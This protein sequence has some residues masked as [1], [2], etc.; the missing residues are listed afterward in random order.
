MGH[1]SKEKEFKKMETMML[2]IND[3]INNIN[4]NQKQNQNQ[5]QKQNQ[6][7]QKQKLRY[8]ISGDFNYDIKEFGDARNSFKLNNTKFYFNPKHIL[9]CCINRNRHNDHVI[10]SLKS[11]NNISIPKVDYMASD[12]KPILVNC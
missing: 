6:K 11:P 9:T 3:Y 7:Q 5:N 10:D 2:E 12:H 8:I 4:K 1:Y